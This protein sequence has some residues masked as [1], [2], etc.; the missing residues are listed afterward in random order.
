MSTHRDF[1]NTARRAR[2]AAYRNRHWLTRFRKGKKG[3]DSTDEWVYGAYC[4]LCGQTV[5][6]MFPTSHK[7]DWEGWKAIGPP[8]KSPCPK[9]VQ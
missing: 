5:L 6:I 3:E 1:R 2:R 8:L 9:S 4:R 7:D